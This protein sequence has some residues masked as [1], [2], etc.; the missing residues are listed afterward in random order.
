[1]QGVADDLARSLH[2]LQVYKRLFA[3]PQQQPWATTVA[4][5]SGTGYPVPVSF[6]KD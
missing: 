4:F 2:S 3:L 1:M 6:F 5:Q